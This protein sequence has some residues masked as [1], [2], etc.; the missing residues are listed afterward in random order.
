MVTRPATITVRPLRAADHPAVLALVTADLLPG[1]PLPTAAGLAQALTGRSP[2]DSR[3]WAELTDLRHHVAVDDLGQV[4]GVI[5]TGWRARD[6]TAVVPWMH[7]GED[8]GLTQVL[9]DSALQRYPDSAVEAFGF[10]TALD[11]GLE[12]LAVTHRAATVAALRAAGFTGKDLWNYMVL[13]D[14]ALTALLATPAPPG[15][16]L[17]EIEQRRLG[18]RL[19]ARRAGQ[20]LGEIE[21]D[22][23]VQ[24]SARIAWLE[25]DPDARGAGWGRTLLRAGLDHAYRAGARRAV[26]YVDDDEPGGARDRSAATALYRRAGFVD[27][28]RL[29]TFHRG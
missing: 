18:W 23:P 8:T 11:L 15:T 19:L 21:I 7:T 4:R 26:L 3:L 2:I 27:V 1:Q 16:P 28:D 25:V 29:H 9:L 6:T 14:Q 12:A 5:A 17:I 24:G 22:H 10:A 13:P 20:L